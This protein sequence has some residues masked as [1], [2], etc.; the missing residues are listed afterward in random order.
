MYA[1]SKAGRLD[2]FDV[3][4][5]LEQKFSPTNLLSLDAL[6]D[7]SPAG[8]ARDR[9]ARSTAIPSELFADS[10]N[11]RATLPQTV[12]AMSSTTGA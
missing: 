4:V 3:G 10:A 8:T 11:E 2:R 7:V 9:A 12:L 5:D 1:R 6:G